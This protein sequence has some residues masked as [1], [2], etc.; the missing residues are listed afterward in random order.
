MNIMT[1][2][3]RTF[4]TASMPTSCDAIFAFISASI[5]AIGF[6]LSK[7]IEAVKLSF[8]Y[9]TIEKIKTTKQKDANNN[10]LQTIVNRLP[11]KEPCFIHDTDLQTNYMSTSNNSSVII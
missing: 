7:Y 3:I 10:T 4:L 2:L 11:H 6:I 1:P 5:I 9:Q 8:Q